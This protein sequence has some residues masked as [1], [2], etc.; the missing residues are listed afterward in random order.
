[1]SKSFLGRAKI[2]LFVIREINKKKNKLKEQINIS[3]N[4]QFLFENDIIKSVFDFYLKTYPEPKFLEIF[5]ILI[6]DLEKNDFISNS[7]VSK[8]FEALYDFNETQ[9]NLLSK[10]N[11]LTHTLNCLIYSMLHQD[12]NMPSDIREE[13]TILA[14]AHDFGKNSNIKNIYAK[15][16]NLSHNEISANYLKTICLKTGVEDEITKRMFL[17]LQNHHNKDNQNNSFFIIELNKID[18]SVREQ[19]LFRIEKNIADERIK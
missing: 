7:S 6:S 16:K 14:L 3:N 12:K 8:K 17:T 9:Y 1:M 4:S 2:G 10:I 11:L 13:I 5:K 18:R 19:E 15:N